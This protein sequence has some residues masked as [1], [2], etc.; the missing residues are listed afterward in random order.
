MT[1]EEH[2]KGLEH[3]SKLIEES[4]IKLNPGKCEFRKSTIRYFGHIISDKG[5]QL[6]KNKIKAILKLPPPTAIPELKRFLGMTHIFRQTC[7]EFSRSTTANVRTFEK[8]YS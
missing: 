5:T 2:D 6:S 7:A 1:M 3:T 4:K 8:G